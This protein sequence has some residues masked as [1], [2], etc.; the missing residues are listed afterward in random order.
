MFLSM[1]SVYNNA[2]VVSYADKIAKTASMQVISVSSSNPDKGT[3]EFTT[4]VNYYLYEITTLSVSGGIFVGISQ[5]AAEK[6]D[7]AFVVA[8]KVNKD[9]YAITM[10]KSAQYGS[11]YSMTPTITRLSDTTFAIAYYSSD[12]EDLTQ[13]TTRYGEFACLHSIHCIMH[14]CMHRE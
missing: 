4:S 11:Q 7:A 8:G 10:T 13:L 14:T 3:V 6:A 1:D 2:Y 5:D 12:A 9:T